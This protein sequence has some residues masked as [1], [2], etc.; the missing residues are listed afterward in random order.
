VK[1]LFDENLSYRLAE[2]LS[3]VYFGSAHLR[4][5]G[6][7]G[8]PDERI[9]Q[10]AHESG[11]VIVSKDSDFSER[12]TLRG[13]PP[14]VIWLRIGNCTTVRA[15]F[16]LRNAVARLHVFESGAKAAW[17]SSI[18]ELSKAL[19]KKSRDSRKSRCNDRICDA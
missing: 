4:N 11:F 3:D 18:H 13:S 10:Y 15:E 5:C 12:S 1:L 2:A 6:L 16:V 9:W 19:L 8:A 17:Y 14:K 7:R